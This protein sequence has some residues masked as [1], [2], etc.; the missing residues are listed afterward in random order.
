MV[1][2]NIRAT[3]WKQGA[4]QA[5]L[6]RELPDVNAVQFSAIVAGNVLPTKGDLRVICGKLNC[7]PTDL[8]DRDELILF[9]VSAA[10]PLQEAEAH[11][12][13]SEKE[14]H[15][16]ME[17]FRVW[18]KPEE[19]EALIRACAILGYTST[20]EWFREAYRE[21]LTRCATIVNALSHTAN[22]AAAAGDERYTIADIPH[23][24]PFSSMAKV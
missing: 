19:K 5:D 6:V 4:K 16:G 8:Y 24:L 12:R 11:L 2:N 23:R 9:E 20:S 13:L 18:M 10:E 1:E 21:A 14:D 3:L 15:A 22:G 17:R 7:Q